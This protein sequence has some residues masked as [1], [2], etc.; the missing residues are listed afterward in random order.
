MLHRLPLLTLP[1]LAA[2]A[3]LPGQWEQQL[4]TTSP[5]ARSGAAMDF[6]PA[7]GGLVLFGGGAP[8]PNSET[9]VYS[10]GVWAQLSP[11]T[12][13]SGRSQMGMVH[14]A[15]RNR[16][17]LYGG[18]ATPISV[19]PPTAETWEFDG[20]TWAQVTTPTNPGPRY[21]HGLAYDLPRGRTVLYGGKATQLLGPPAG[22]TWEYDGVAWL[23]RTPANSPGP[24]ERAAMCYLNSAGGT[25]LFGGFDGSTVRDQTWIYDGTDWTQVATT[26]PR[27]PARL[28]AQMVADPGRGVAV[29]TGGQDGSGN[30]FDDTWEF[31]GV[32]W[33]Q[34]PTLPATQPG[35][36]HALGFHL[37]DRQVV[38]FGGF[39]AA[40]N[41]LS[42][43]TWEFGARWRPYGTGCLGSAGVPLLSMPDAPRLGGAFTLDLQN[44]N[45]AP[46]LAVVVLGLVQ[47]PEP[48][49]PLDVLG[50][51][52]CAGYVSPDVLANVPTAGGVA[53]YT[54]TPVF[55]TVG[56]RIYAQA[57]CLDPGVNP[58]WLVASNAVAT[59]LGS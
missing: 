12:S 3:T 1:F 34:Q 23:Q 15:A 5:T 51:T 54:W 53:T 31:D 52:G 11:A 17:V 13:P 21:R 47:A 39:V 9:W 46:L 6:F 48:G 38:R 25:V 37:F 50:L 36:D 7:L 57:L 14:D 49:I 41:S 44:L 18:L 8:F 59:T 32:T 22:D 20:S 2:A 45:P 56:D 33:T 16:M 19:P 43:Q 58:A 42:N 29:L 4:P 28:S 27:P 30:L 35:R 10:S 40:P 26:G 24:R 55:G